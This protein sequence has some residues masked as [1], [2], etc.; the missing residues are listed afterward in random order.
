MELF[1]I[2]LNVSLELLRVLC[3]SVKSFLL[4]DDILEVAIAGGAVSRLGILSLNALVVE[5]VST[6]KVNGRQR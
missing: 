1:G 4:L 2:V 6:H 5:G 3:V